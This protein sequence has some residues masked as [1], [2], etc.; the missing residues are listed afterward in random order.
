M[1]AARV[2][3][4]IATNNLANTSSDGF[5]KQ[6]ARGRIGANGVTTQAIRSRE[7]GALRHTGRTLDLAIVGPGAFRL[8]SADGSVSVTRAGGFTRDRFGRLTDDA[9]SVL[10]GPHG[11]VRIGADA[12]DTQT[13][14]LGLPPGASI[15]SGFLET[16]NVNPITE[17]IDVLGAQRSYESVQK[18]LL[19]IDETRSKAS[20]ELARLNKELDESCAVC[21]RLRDGR[22]TN[23]P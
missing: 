19:A 20:N 21:C 2:R 16:S 1:N 23:Q 4:D 5:R 22:T 12:L 10:L 17:M 3:L 6:E 18:T 9:G 11:P 8:Q 15:R 13:L 14:Q 7:Q